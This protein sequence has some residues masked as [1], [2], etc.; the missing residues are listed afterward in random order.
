MLGINGLLIGLLTSKAD[1]V[2]NNKN[3]QIPVQ[4]SQ[5]PD[6][7]EKR[8]VEIIYEKNDNGVPILK[9]E[10]TGTK[11][12][13]QKIDGTELYRFERGFNTDTETVFSK[14]GKKLY[15]VKYNPNGSYQK[16]VYC[17][18]GRSIKTI[19]NYNKDGEVKN[20]K[21]VTPEAR[22]ELSKEEIESITKY[23]YHITSPNNFKSM[24]NDGFIRAS[25]DSHLHKEGN[26]AVFLL[27]G[28][29]TLSK[30]N[31]IHNGEERSYITRLLQYC[32]KD[33]NGNVLILRIPTSKL[34]INKIKFRDQDEVLDG[35]PMFQLSRKEEDEYFGFR[36][37]YEKIHPNQ[38]RPIGKLSS[39]IFLTERSKRLTNGESVS[40]LIKKKS[41]PLEFLYTGNIPIETIQESQT[42]DVSKLMKMSYYDKTSED[43]AIELLKDFLTE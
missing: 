14:D 33:K 3:A 13:I 5:V 8:K 38:R 28:Q 9:L 19:I 22:I 4:K 26:Q 10:K 34:D 15:E 31:S 32:N 17:E 16:T 43:Y 29:N 39:D 27:D 1:N 21:I 20:K 42:I 12:S 35:F 24:T 37:L 7:F 23:F 36:R 30:W 25:T 6:T 18:D 11:S 2:K 40:E 41:K